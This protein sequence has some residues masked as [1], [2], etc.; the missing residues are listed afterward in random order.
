MQVDLR[1][2]KRN[3]T[4]GVTIP[5]RM[6][7]ALRVI[8]TRE[9]NLYSVIEI[10]LFFRRAGWLPKSFRSLTVPIVWDS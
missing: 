9:V 8:A 5:I 4:P 3:I 7:G 6:D 1:R 2:K 10:V